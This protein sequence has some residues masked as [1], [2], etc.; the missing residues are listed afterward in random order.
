MTAYTIKIRPKTQVLCLFHYI[1]LFLNFDSTSVIDNTS[2]VLVQ[3]F[4]LFICFNPSKFSSL[5]HL[6]SYFLSSLQKFI[7]LNKNI[8]IYAKKNNTILKEN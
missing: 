8:A 4:L 7:R 3:Y 2:S 6:N 5:I 1:F